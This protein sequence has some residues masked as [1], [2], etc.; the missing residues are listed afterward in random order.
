MKV[1]LDNVTKERAANNTGMTVRQAGYIP[2]EVEN[3]LWHKN[4]L[5]EDTPYKLGENVLFLLSINLGLCACDEHYALHRGSESQP[6][7]LLLEHSES[8]KRC[9]VYRGDSI[10]KTNGCGLK[11]FTNYRKVVWIYRSENVTHCPVCLVDKYISLL[12]PVSPKNNKNHF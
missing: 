3:K 8:C 4:I 6:S 1:L 7:Q 12:P 10:T 2:S 5:G 9:L 11:S